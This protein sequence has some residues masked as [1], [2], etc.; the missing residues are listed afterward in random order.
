MNPVSVRQSEL[1]KQGLANLKAVA[2]SGTAPTRSLALTRRF[3]AQAEQQLP[4]L[5]GP[6]TGVGLYR[7]LAG[8]FDPAVALQ[9]EL[10]ARGARL[11]YPRATEPGSGIMDFAWVPD[12]GA[13]AS[14]PAGAHGIQEPAASC[15]RAEPA[16]LDWILVPGVAFGPEGN[17]IGR[18][19]GYFDRYLV[20]APQA[21]RVSVAWDELW[22]GEFPAQSWDQR[23]DWLV[24][25]TLQDPSDPLL[26]LERR[27]N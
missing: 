8:E 17:R 27:R 23:I 20:R 4:R 16:A 14:W 1:R 13:A 21:V 6:G 3:L 15:P 9:S 24:L 25:E 7:A 11:A 5:L 26:R 12:P 19:A 22:V 18:G 10:L 2:A